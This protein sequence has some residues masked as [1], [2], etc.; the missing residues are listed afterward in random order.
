MYSQYRN[1]CAAALITMA[2]V[3]DFK[4]PKLQAIAS[5]R[6]EGSAWSDDLRT[7][8]RETSRLC[9]SVVRELP[10]QGRKPRFNS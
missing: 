4:Q 8:L 5:E 3:P 1:D 6:L 7:E 2:A 9:L 10:A